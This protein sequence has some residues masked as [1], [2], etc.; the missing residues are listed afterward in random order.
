MSQAPR[1]DSASSPT[2]PPSAAR[3]TR[4]RTPRIGSASA[5][6]S[7]RER[8][9][10]AVRVFGCAGSTIETVDAIEWSVDNGM[11]VINMSLGNVVRDGHGPVCSRRGQRSAG[12][13]RRRCR[14]PGN[15]GPSQ[16]I[17]GAPATGH[18]VV[19]VAANES[20]STF[21]GFTL[22]LPTMPS[23]I[24]AINANG[25][26]DVR[27]RDAV[28]DRLRQRQPGNANGRRVAR[29]QRV[30]LSRH[31]RTRRRWRSSSA[32]SAPA[33]GRPSAASRPATRRWRW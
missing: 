7:L 31:R 8:I 21:P 19:S 17:G 10:Y 13:H 29:L 9:I 30:R 11:D 14:L 32:V 16:Y 28:H 20:L 25:E 26:P 6:E 27:E 12:G 4:R 18:H 2:A 3:T 33:S 15:N 1:P 22:T 24:T 23:P 5:P